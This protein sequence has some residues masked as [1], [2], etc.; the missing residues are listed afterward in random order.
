MEYKTRSIPYDTP[1]D[2]NTPQGI[3]AYLDAA[4][5]DEDEQVLLMALRNATAAI[6][7]MSELARRTGLTR[8]TLNRT[9]SDSGNL[10]F[11]NLRAILKA[12][13]LGLSVRSE[14][15]GVRGE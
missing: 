1:A 10:K 7:G 4:M 2:L 3:A 5:E 6:G 9:L 8:E 13:G 12:M 11:S 15:E 14:G